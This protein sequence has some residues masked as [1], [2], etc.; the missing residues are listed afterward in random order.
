MSLERLEFNVSVDPVGRPGSMLLEHHS[1]HGF[2][3]AL[4][5]DLK[6]PVGIWL[7]VKIYA[8]RNYGFG[9]KWDHITANI[10]LWEGLCHM[11][12][13]IESVL[14]FFCMKGQIKIAL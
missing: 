5:M 11:I 9:V 13:R 2:F 12:Y 14:N 1:Y 6:I 3:G 10:L 7:W 8:C 4:G